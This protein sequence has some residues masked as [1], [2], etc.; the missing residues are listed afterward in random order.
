MVEPGRTAVE[1]A[2]R[3]GVKAVCAFL[4]QFSPRRRYDVVFSAHVLEHVPDI[5]AFLSQC[6]S[7]L[8]NNGKLI[9]LTPNARAWKFKLLKSRWAWAA[10]GNHLNFLSKESAII[11]L[12]RN[13]FRL[14]YIQGLRPGR[15]HYPVMLTRCLS[16]WYTRI[17]SRT[18]TTLLSA[19]SDTGVSPH[20]QPK[21]SGLKA[22]LVSSGRKMG[23]P[24]LWAEFAILSLLDILAGE[25]KA[26]ELLIVAS[27]KE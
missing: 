1:A 20:L 3:R 9:F 14:D 2:K 21:R 18:Q 4:H 8:E 11:L 17:F 25:D 13:G 12:E 27:L 6:G 26:D 24:L 5:A 23:R 19:A 15:A 16:E 22:A 7:L 10:P